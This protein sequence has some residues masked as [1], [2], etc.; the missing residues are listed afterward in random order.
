MTVEV[1]TFTGVDQFTRLDEVADISRIYPGAEFGILV[2]SRTDSVIDG[3]I[4]PPLF[5][6]NSFRRLAQTTQ[7]RASLHLCGKYARKLYELCQ[8]FDRVQVNLHGDEWSPDRIGVDVSAVL[9]FMGMVYPAKVILQH[10]GPF[11]TVPLLDP[12]LEYLFDVSEGG[13]VESFDHWPEPHNHPASIS[14]RVG[15]AG[16]LGP[17]NIRRAVEFAEWYKDTPMWFDMEGRIRK[18][19]WLDLDAVRDVCRLVWPP[20]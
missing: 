9:Q 20:A 18:D 6:V 5:V 10:R 13:G 19:G 8:G 1:V 17:H 7:L 15:Y 12:Q 2:G 11:S 3:G 4:F 16:G 14:G